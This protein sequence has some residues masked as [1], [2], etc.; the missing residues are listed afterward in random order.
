MLARLR[1]R[2]SSSEI[3][4]R[5]AKKR[6]NEQA[7]GRE[8]M[9]AH[10]LMS[11]Q[12]TAFE[13]ERQALQAQ[14]SHLQQRIRSL[15]EA[16][17]AKGP[18][19]QSDEALVDVQDE[20]ATL[21]VSYSTVLAQLNTTSK[22]VSELRQANATLREE[23]EGWEFL[24]RERTFAGTLHPDREDDWAAKPNDPPNKPGLGQLEALDEE[25]EMDELHSD[26]E[27]QSP[28]LDDEQGFIR[29]LDHNDGPLLSKSPSRYL[30][31]PGSRRKPKGESLGD[32]PLTSSGLDL[33]AELGRAE[34]DLEGD[35]MRVLGKGDEGE[36]ES[37][38]SR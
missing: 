1:E 22:E 34:V 9:R 31:A 5:E 26:L 2:L 24:V 35:Q 13:T 16:K 27:A 28:I 37:A 33:A 6:S 18:S 23:N 25:M 17:P 10:L 36:G 12:E 20:L 38:R 8:S 21:K 3:Q 11:A 4:V 7:S 32:L 14:E 29:D 30:A 19:Q 15:M